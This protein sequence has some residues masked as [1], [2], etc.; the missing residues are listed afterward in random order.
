MM[1]RN[2]MIVWLMACV[3]SMPFAM[4]SC[5]SDDDEPKTPSENDVAG[6]P[7]L[8]ETE[9]GLY[10]DGKMKFEIKDAD[11]RTLS[12]KTLV[13]YD[14]Y[15]SLDIP[16]YVNIKGKRYSVVE[17]GL[18]AFLG[19]DGNNGLKKDTKLESITLP[20]TLQTIQDAA[21]IGCTA[22]KSIF[23]PKNVSYIGEEAPFFFCDALKKIEVDKANPNYDSRNNSNC[24]IQTKKGA[25]LVGCMNSVI[26]TD[27]DVTSIAPAAFI[28]C[29]GLEKITIPANITK[30]G[31]RAFYYC[32]NLKELSCLSP[33]P[34]TLEDIDVFSFIHESCV[35]YVPKGCK[36]TYANA[37]NWPFKYDDI[38]AIY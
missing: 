26:P 6:L 19:P 37:E 34:P 8:T 15:T 1:K 3:L 18:T 22:L 21:F 24:I 35:L 30:I 12:L 33:T 14:T 13:E 17:I 29:T 9:D 32:N 28:A 11:G 16:A 7:L 25:V 20:N 38:V 23:I 27:P 4:V 36:E 10:T 31:K 5:S 2:R